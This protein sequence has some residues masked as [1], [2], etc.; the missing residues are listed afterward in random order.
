VVN[1]A[2]IRL[3]VHIV[4]KPDTGGFLG[5]E[6]IKIVLIQGFIVELVAKWLG[7]LNDVCTVSIL[8]IINDQTQYDDSVGDQGWSGQ[9]QLSTVGNDQ[10]IML[11]I[12][13]FIQV[14]S[15]RVIIGN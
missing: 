9:A 6:E 14:L 1:N 7:C 10:H 13:R 8:H 15:C 4:D 11:V 12:D 5:A 2:F 3:G